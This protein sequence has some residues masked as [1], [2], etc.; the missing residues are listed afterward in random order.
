LLATTV[1]AV[2][3]FAFAIYLA[4]G[5]AFLTAARR[6]IERHDFSA[7]GLLKNRASSW[8]AHADLYFSR[9]M[10]AQSQTLPDVGDRLRGWLF[11]KQAATRA[12]ET[13]ED[14]HNALVNLAA[15]YAVENNAPM[16]E[17]CLREA[18][19]AAPNWFKSHWLLAQVLARD[20]R[21]EEALRE[22]RLAVQLDGGKD[23]E[24]A[25]TL[26]ELEPK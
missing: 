7:A 17:R 14:W 19:Q 1:P 22:A 25:Q 21:R 20:G 9:Q 12:A 2:F 6:A 8:G 3:F 23:P 5:D 13:A 4:T 15:F 11:A 24:V 10:L 26:A 16:V 18:A